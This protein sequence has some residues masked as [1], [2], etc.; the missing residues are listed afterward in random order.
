MEPGMIP[1]CGAARAPQEAVTFND[2]A[3]DFTQ[4]EW[5]HLDPSQKELYR[6]VMLENYRNLLSLVGLPISKPDVISQLEQ[7]EAPRVLEVK[8]VGAHQDPT[9]QTSATQDKLPEGQR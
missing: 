7:E 3:V 2:V 9:V 6:D 8:G 5:K 4:D 1:V